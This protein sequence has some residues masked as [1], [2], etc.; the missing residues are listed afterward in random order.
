MIVPEVVVDID[1]APTV[2]QLSEL[3]R[4]LV[5]P[6]CKDR[7]SKGCGHLLLARYGNRNNPMTGST[8]LF[9]LKFYITHLCY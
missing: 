1:R 3:S 8:L 9:H 6:L 4:R 7:A 5:C 2:S